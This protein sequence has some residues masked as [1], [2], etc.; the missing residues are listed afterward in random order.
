MKF[1]Q[2]L[3]AEPDEIVS[4]GRLRDASNFSD[5]NR[6][7]TAFQFVIRDFSYSKRSKDTPRTVVEINP[8]AIAA[9]LEEID[10]SNP[11]GIVFEG[12]AMLQ[13]MEA[14][15]LHHPALPMTVDFHN[16][17]GVLYRDVKEARSPWF[18]RALL[19]PLRAARYRAVEAADK[20]AAALADTVWVCSDA[21]RK[22]VE[23]LAPGR[24]VFTVPNPIPQWEISETGAGDSGDDTVVFV[25]HLGYEPNKFA[26]RFLARRVA[27]RLFKAR[28]QAQLHV[29][30][31]NPSPELVGFLRRRGVHVTANPVSLA[32]IYS[33]AAV[34]AIP[35]RHGGGTRI[36]V[37]EALAAG[38]P[39]VATN[40]AVEG[41]GMEPDR[42]FL[43]AET[44]DEFVA[45]IIRVLDSPQLQGRLRAA[46]RDFVQERYSDA[47]RARAVQLALEALVTPADG[48]TSRR[49]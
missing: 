17:E 12:V 13:A 33:S 25:G 16:V 9:L 40:K 22:A 26:V 19:W 21:D 32:P 6:I 43:H 1:L 2:V 14:V 41:L 39:V 29:C 45:S 46:G 42:H 34:T 28:P 18:L 11:Q 47:A 5:L 23:L 15:R 7:G 38:C 31:R 49:A 36:K 4:G 3:L 20:R 8:R 24:P 30:G 35:L 10:R 27:P 44:A 37:L 48:A